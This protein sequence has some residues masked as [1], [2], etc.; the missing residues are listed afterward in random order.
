MEGLTTEGVPLIA[1]V[2]VSKTIPVGRD[3]VIDQLTA[4][5]PAAVGTTGAVIA[6]PFVKVNEFGL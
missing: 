2:A 4:G 5:S 1:P 3:G 6:V